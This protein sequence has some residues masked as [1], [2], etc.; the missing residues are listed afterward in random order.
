MQAASTSVNELFQSE[1][2]L[3]V[4]LFQRRYVWVEDAHL[5]PFWFD[6]RARAALRLAETPAPFPH[7]MGAI[8]LQADAQ[9]RTSRI[10]DGQQRL[11]TLYLTLAA[12]RR[13]AAKRELDHLALAAERRL[14]LADGARRLIATAAD[15]EFLD[16][17]VANGALDDLADLWPDRFAKG[18]SR[19]LKSVAEP[20]CLSAYVGF[21]ERVERFAAGGDA[22]PATEPEVAAAAEAQRIEGLLLALLDDFRVVAI[23]LEP[24]DDGP[25]IFEALNDRGA[26]LTAGDLVRNDVVRRA[27][28]NGEDAARLLEQSW[29][30]LAE[31][32]FWRANV[33]VGRAK[34]AQ[35][36]NLLRHYLIASAAAPASPSRVFHGYRTYISRRPPPFPSVRSELTR[37]WEAAAVYRRL[38]AADDAEDKAVALDPE[39]AAVLTLTAER[40][41]AWAPSAMLGPLMAAAL[42][43]EAQPADKA[44][45]FHLIVGY[46]IRRDVCGLNRRNLHRSGAALATTV[47]AADPSRL[48]ATVASHLASRVGADGLWPTDALFQLHW[49]KEPIAAGAG[50]ARALSLLV[51]LEAERSGRSPADIRAERPQIDHVMPRDW[52][53]A[54]RTRWPDPPTGF[55]VA[56]DDAFRARGHAIESI[57]NLALVEP[58]LNASLGNSGF[59]DRRGG[60]RQSKYVTTRPLADIDVWAEPAIEAR[61]A[62][63]L[64]AAIKLWPGPNHLAAQP[65]P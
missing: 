2:G 63:L 50:A 15:D 59:E 12:I 37:L 51:E 29:R 1:R 19:L 18:R 49:L 53:D 22:D 24:G 52:S 7:F 55:G 56:L 47:A 6:L 26:P 14:W 3:R 58:K 60:Y 45:A 41:G 5:A 10:I 13:T 28:A 32:P 21:L 54:A 61:A 16:P 23:E 17:I 65:Q 46:L 48:S 57:G 4:P 33:K 62:S 39:L 11:I 20:D 64:G 25:A 8:L 40:I 27:R 38:L 9:G 30:P 35:L 43:P 44:A 42:A 31:T 34:A 36:D